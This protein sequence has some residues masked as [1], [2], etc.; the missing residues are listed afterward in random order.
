MKMQKWINVDER[1]PKK[2]GMSLVHS[3]DDKQLCAWYQDGW[4]YYDKVSD[5]I[6]EV[7]TKITHWMPRPEPPKE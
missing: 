4:F 6:I 1:L 7:E 5:S 3:E 2:T